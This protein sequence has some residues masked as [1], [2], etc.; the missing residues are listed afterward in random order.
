VDV[1]NEGTS[2]GGTSFSY[3]IS[4]F[5]GDVDEI[6]DEYMHLIGQNLFDHTGTMTRG[7]NSFRMYYNARH[8]VMLMI[9][10]E[11]INGYECFTVS[12]S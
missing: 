5:P 8:G 7:G 3:R 4:D 9:G 11:S 1:F 10:R 12:V 2:Y 6:I